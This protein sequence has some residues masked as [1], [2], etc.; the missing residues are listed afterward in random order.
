MAH[1]NNGHKLIAAG[2]AML[3]AE[4]AL[5]LA[6]TGGIGII[7]GL[8]AGAIAYTAVDEI[9]Q[10]TGREFSLPARARS[11]Q[12]H[13]SLLYRMVHGRST[14]GDWLDEDGEDE[15]EEYEEEEPDTDPLAERLIELS[16]EVVLRPNDLIAKAL[17]IVA[18][19]RTGK[20]TL[21]RL[22][23]QEI[24]GFYV[25]LFIPNSEGDYTSLYGHLPRGIIA[26]AP[27]IYSHD[28]VNLWEVIPD[29]ADVLGFNILA[30]G[31]QVIFEMDTFDDPD[32]AWQVVIGVIKGMYEFARQYPQDRCP[33]HVFLD[34]AQKYLPQ[35]LSASAIAN[36]QTRD[37]LLK[38]YGGMF[39]S[40]GKRGITPVII[41]QRF[42]E[43]NN[44]ILAQAEL[45]F[46]LRQTH[47]TDLD[48]CMKY[49]RKDVA[50]RQTI[51]SFAP[52]EGIF[53]A[54]DDLQL[55]TQFY[56][57]DS[58]GSL[59]QTPQAERATRF[60]NRPLPTQRSLP[61]TPR[62]VQD[63]GE[64]ER[65]QEQRLPQPIRRKIDPLV[66]R[67][68]QAMFRLKTAGQ[69]QT[70]AAI[71]VAT[72]IDLWEV[73]K[74]WPAILN[75]CARLEEEAEQQD[76]EAEEATDLEEQA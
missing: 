43:T 1:K 12:T 16:P 19:R 65:Q 24:A 49:V 52:G 8:A 18:Q 17:L 47:D 74:R 32:D 35:D 72:G 30:E 2:T 58:D 57:G 53:I 25:P 75:E 64:D 54:D 76:G 67:A 71:V 28:E 40:G 3:I 70:Q 55:V 62:P 7:V 9:E 66:E 44:K 59:S 4:P 50:N 29:E 39:A 41:S 61:N 37:E 22:I 51:A 45:R 36:K 11:D 46:I 63:E 31:L 48:R 23:A 38:A 69:K 33:V 20:T 13:G 27:G 6:H 73:R 60:I 68:G 5:A 10:A 34:E 14:R 56:Q 21:A 15:G 42:A 26:A